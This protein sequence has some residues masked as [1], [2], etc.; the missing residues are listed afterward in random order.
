MESNSL[1]SLNMF[2]NEVHVERIEASLQWSTL[3]IHLTKSVSDIWGKGELLDVE[4]SPVLT[5]SFV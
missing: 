5:S 4:D 2:D 3:G 1:L